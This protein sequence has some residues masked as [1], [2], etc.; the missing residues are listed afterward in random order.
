MLTD[1]PVPVAHNPRSALSVIVAVVGLAGVAALF[2]PLAWNT[3]PLAAA[4]T[5]PFLPGGGDSYLQGLWRLGVP[6]LLALLVSA[7]AMRRL[8]SRRFSRA[9]RVLAY[10]A[11][12]VAACCLLS[13][14]VPGGSG[15][16]RSSPSSVMDWFMVAFP[17]AG[18]AAGAYLLRR[19]SRTGVPDAANA[20]TAMQLVYVIVAI[21]C[22]VAYASV[23][24]QVGA[25]LVAL[26]TLAYLAQIVAVFVAAPGRT[27]R[28]VADVVRNTVGGDRR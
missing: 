27:P 23:G 17:W 11:A 12:L 24:W 25:Y 19:N 18:L 15:D 7:G 9:E 2:L 14:F 16:G 3:S 5:L 21:L 6:F 22:L 10:L 28:T 1:R 20:V 26:T 13:L 8:V 4:G